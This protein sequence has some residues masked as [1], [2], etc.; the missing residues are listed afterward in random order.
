MST[1][2]KV[3]PRDAGHPYRNHLDTHKTRKTRD[4]AV[5][6]HP[7]GHSSHS[8]KWVTIGPGGEA[9]S[10]FTGT[11][12]HLHVCGLPHLFCLRPLGSTQWLL[13]QD[14]QPQATVSGCVHTN[15]GFTYD[16]LSIAAQPP[17]RC[18]RGSVR[19]TPLTS[20]LP[21]SQDTLDPFEGSPKSPIFLRL[22]P[23]SPKSPKP[24]R[25]PRRT[26]SLRHQG[27]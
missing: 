9:S 7:L 24:S 27:T 21:T 3:L 26:S 5:D 25:F 10:G 14:A 18:F 4:E 20:L 2:S 22:P 16:L 12:S 8:T 13:T 11:A 6:D 23:K 19:G 17:H 15:S 1:P